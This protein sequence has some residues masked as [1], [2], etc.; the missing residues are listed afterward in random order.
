MSEMIT[1]RRDK[2][3]ALIKKADEVG[4]LLADAEKNHGGLIGPDTLRKAN[5]LRLELSRWK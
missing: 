5:E 2:L 3:D 4:E 1:V